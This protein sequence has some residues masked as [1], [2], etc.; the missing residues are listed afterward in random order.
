VA[1]Y[2]VRTQTDSDDDAEQK[3]EQLA[4]VYEQLKPRLAERW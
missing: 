3:I 1:S 4:L 2:I